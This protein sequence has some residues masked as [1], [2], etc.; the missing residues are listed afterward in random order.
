[1]LEDEV[2]SLL[3]KEWTDE[4]KELI[5]NLIST[6]TYFKRMLP[7][8]FKQDILCALQMC[9]S[10]KIELDLYR[11]KCTCTFPTMLSKCECQGECKCKCQS[12]AES[13]CECQ[14]EC[15]CKCQ[16]EAESKCEEK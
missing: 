9:N 12:E 8:T 1:M 10:L 7:K 15:K 4:E 16:S 3:E 2:K 14:G 13:K 11:K 5:T 6:V